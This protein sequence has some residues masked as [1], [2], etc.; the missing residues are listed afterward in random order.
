MSRPRPPMGWNP[1]DCFG[2]SVTGDDVLAN[3]HVIHDHLLPH[4]W[5]TV[6]VDIQWYEDGY[7][8]LQRPRPPGAGRQ[9]ANCRARR[10]SRRRPTAGASPD[11]RGRCTTSA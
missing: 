3:A 1:W 11:W 2:G 8:R 10:G 4:G 7:P 5:D 6:V 9:G